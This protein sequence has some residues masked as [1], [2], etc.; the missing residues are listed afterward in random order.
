MF[1][2]ILLWYVGTV[3]IVFVITVGM[4]AYIQSD[5]DKDHLDFAWENLRE[6]GEAFVRE[7]ESTGTPPVDSPGRR[8]SRIWVFDES[9]SELA[10]PKPPFRGKEDAEGDSGDF[11]PEGKPEGEGRS[12][13]MSLR[14]ANRTDVRLPRKSRKPP[15]WGGFGPGGSMAV[16]LASQAMSLIVD[17]RENVVFEVGEEDFLGCRVIGP[18][19]K[20]YGVFT[21]SRP[22]TLRMLL[23][24][25]SRP[26]V[27]LR[28]WVIIL[29]VVVLCWWLARYL[30]RPVLDVQTLVGHIAGGDYQKRLPDSLVG[31]YDEL[32]SLAG[33]MNRVAAAV[34]AVIKGQQQLLRDVSHELRSPLARIRISLE[35]LRSENEKIDSGLLTKIE[36]DVDRLNELIQ[37][38]LDI[39][40]LDQFKA[41]PLKLEPVNVGEFLTRILGTVRFEAE[42]Q[43]KCIRFEPPPEIISISASE[44]YLRR[45]VENVLRNAVRHSP[46]GGEIKV[47]LSRVMG[48]GGENRVRIGIRDQGPGVPPEKVERLFD[49]FFRCEEDRGRASGGSGLGLAIVRKAIDAHRGEA[50]ARN[51]P[52]GGLEIELLLPG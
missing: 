52:A 23:F 6:E 2:K 14:A 18:S 32:G 40:R 42:P 10:R 49:P 15:P 13:S 43:K 26:S 4:M 35:L 17:S 28:I 1:A 46:E 51:L 7:F 9:G 31:R 36:R 25:L 29:V 47:D 8:P 11:R 5:A 33:D 48:P 41:M 12:G 20:R 50:R 19:G 3:L 22:R 16:D 37:Q 24:F 27:W 44:E 30:V 21:W 34:E 39:S 38:V 45:A